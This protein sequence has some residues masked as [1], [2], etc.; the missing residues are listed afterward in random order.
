MFSNT[1]YRQFNPIFLM[2]YRFS[3]QIDP[4]DFESE[5]IFKFLITKT[6]VSGNF[7][8]KDKANHGKQLLRDRKIQQSRRRFKGFY[9]G[10]LGIPGNSTWKDHHL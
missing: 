10:L 1:F 6:L 7:M 2:S 5:L 8:Y 3:D 9:N 4:A